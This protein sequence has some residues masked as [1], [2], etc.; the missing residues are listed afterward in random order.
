MK[1]P[2][3][4]G[5]TVSFKSQV[6]P[7]S[8]SADPFGTCRADCSVYAILGNSVLLKKKHTHTQVGFQAQV[9]RGGET[10]VWR[11]HRGRRYSRV[12]IS[13]KMAC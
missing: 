11:G 4:A 3:L 5:A 10:F 2:W 9:D 7:Y 6:I 12:S 13:G 8:L 1:D